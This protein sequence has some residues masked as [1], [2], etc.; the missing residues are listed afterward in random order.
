MA[1]QALSVAE[2]FSQANMAE[3]QAKLQGA[4]EDVAALQRETDRKAELVRSISS[5]R[6]QTGA[7][8]IELSGS[9]LTVIEESIRQERI[10]T[11]RDKFNT[12]VAKQSALFR[13]ATQAR[14]LRVR[15]GLSLLRTAEKA[16][17]SAPVGG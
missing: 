16:V 5:Q 9:P 8:G 2:S 13:G 1:V 12:A 10:D 11:S 3:R 14:G 6:A 17:A 4:M 7:S 15:A